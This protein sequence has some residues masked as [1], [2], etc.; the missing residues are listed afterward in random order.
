MNDA[1]FVR[2]FRAVGDLSRD[3]ERFIDG[4]SP[5]PQPLGQVLTLDHLHGEEVR[6]GTVRQGGAL[7]AIKVHVLDRGVDGADLIP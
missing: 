3:R 1:F 6:S 7:E 4:N 2:L 5:S